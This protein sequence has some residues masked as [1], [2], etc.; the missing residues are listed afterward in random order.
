MEYKQYCEKKKTRIEKR[1]EITW[2]RGHRRMS[3]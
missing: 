3:C 1:G 2:R